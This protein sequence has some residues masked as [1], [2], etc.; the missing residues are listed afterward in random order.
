MDP[1]TD[2]RRS[3][4]HG[5]LWARWLAMPMGASAGAGAAAAL[6][7][8][9]WL[10]ENRLALAS[11]AGWYDVYVQPF[12]TGGVFGFTLATLAFRLA[13]S[14][15]VI[16]TALTSVVTST[17]ALMLVGHATL[18]VPVHPQAFTQGMSAVVATIIGVGVGN[19][20]SERAAA[21]ASTDVT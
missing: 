8:V 14:N 6:T 7:L 10:L 3:P 5:W 11:Q 9:P 20:R 15:K 1:R 4:Q 16:A 17:I 2:S 21:A 18:E 19:A 12:V 13:P